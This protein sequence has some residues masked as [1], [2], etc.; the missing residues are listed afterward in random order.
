[1]HYKKLKSWF[2]NIDNTELAVYNSGDQIKMP[3][4]G[5]LWQ[6]ELMEL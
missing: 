6:G 1:M 4:G 3:A 2:N 5:I